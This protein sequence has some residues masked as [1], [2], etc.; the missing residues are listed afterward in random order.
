MIVI[1]Y[2]VFGFDTDT[3]KT[4]EATFDFIRKSEIDV[5]PINILTPYPG[6]PL[7]KQL[8][9]QGRILT[10]NWDKYTTRDVVFKP[11]KMTAEQLYEQ[12]INLYDNIYKISNRFRRIMK[13][14]NYGT[15]HLISSFVLNTR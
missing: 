1:G 6:T 9:D 7:F 3:K 4:F 13:S 15:S 14:V 2:F 5:I 11:K 10:K 8:N 12:T